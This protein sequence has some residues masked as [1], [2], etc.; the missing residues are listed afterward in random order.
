M[1]EESVLGCGKLF[2]KDRFEPPRFVLIVQHHD[3][4]NAKGFAARTALR[5][6]LIH[7]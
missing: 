7:I 5:L 2:G 4:N 6:S 1:V 3:G